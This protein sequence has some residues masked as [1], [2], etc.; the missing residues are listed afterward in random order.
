MVSRRW[1]PGI[2]EVE[3]VGAYNNKEMNHGDMKQ[4]SFSNFQRIELILGKLIFGSLRLCGTGEIWIPIS[5]IIMTESKIY[6]GSL[7]A[8]LVITFSSL[9]RKMESFFGD[10]AISR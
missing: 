6:R 9:S 7:S 10:L 3:W 2:G 4:S 5:I 8:D 1:D